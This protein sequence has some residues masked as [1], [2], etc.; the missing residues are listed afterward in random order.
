MTVACVTSCYTDANQLHMQIIT[1][2]VT[3]FYAIYTPFG[4]IFKITDL[5]LA[6]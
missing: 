2:F 5:A 1:L 4:N 6:M 3:S